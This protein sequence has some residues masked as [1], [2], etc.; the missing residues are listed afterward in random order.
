MKIRWRTAPALVREG[1]QTGD[2]RVIVDGAGYWQDLPLALRWDR[3][4][5]GGHTGA[6][7][8]G[9]IEM[10]ERRDAGVVY[11]EGFIDDE[12]ADGAELV[13]SLG[14]H[15]RMG[16]SIDPDDIAAE[17]RAT[18]DAAEEF[19]LFAA[20]GDPDD[21]EDGVVLF[22]YA[23]DEMIERWTRYRIRAATVV[24]T[25]AFI[26]AAIELVDEPAVE[27]E[28]AAGEAPVAASGVQVRPA[29]SA[30]FVAEP[31]VDDDRLVDQPGGRVA[32]PLSI[33]DD[34]RTVMGHLAVWDECH[35]GYPGVCVTAPASRSAYAHF[36][37]GS[38]V[39]D[40]GLPVSTGAL[41][42][43]C[44][45]ADA[46]LFAEGARDH[47]A[48]SGM[49]WADVRVVDGQWGPWVCGVLR[50]SVTDEQV[51]V[52]RASSLS[53]DWRR[54][55]DGLELIGVL[56]VNTPG[57]PVARVASTSLAAAARPSVAV[58]GRE[59][60]S[61]TAA[62]LV[63]RCAECAERARQAA[64]AALPGGGGV[65]TALDA[66]EGHLR[67]QGRL[68]RALDARTRHLVPAAAAA[69]AARIRGE[70]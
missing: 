57:F 61:L 68:L 46:H 51:R 37:V 19:L 27:D 20:A 17:V 48:H 25:A 29:R 52:L 21:A 6:V 35:V 34:A 53:G 70:G 7:L 1:V 14:V 67:A 43:G 15:G 40:E 55:D 58:V 36:H 65:L 10:I 54:R 39:V 66:M 64:A 22:E 28:S 59:Q 2:G 49:A 69:A 63:H 5:D 41:T 45:H 30:F 4:D 24:D 9:Q 33:D 31:D 16:V 44:D 18:G 13:R 62:G 42:I 47:Y 11:A 60:V 26:D 56:A 32:M 50:P 38:V 23:T 12:S 8:V 3:E